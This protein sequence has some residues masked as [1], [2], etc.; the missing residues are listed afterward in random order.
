MEKAWAKGVEYWITPASAIEMDA[1]VDLFNDA[2]SQYYVDTHVTP[3][4]LM[5]LIDRE[6]ISVENSFIVSSGQY[7]VGV[8]FLAIRGERGYICGMGVRL[9][10]QGRGLGELL[11]RRAIYQARTL[12]L[13]SLQLDEVDR[14]FRAE[15]LYRK[16][17]FVQVR[18]LGM[19]NRDGLPP[20][21]AVPERGAIDVILS[22]A[23]SRD[24]L[25][26][27]MVFNEVRPCW[28][29]EVVSLGRLS[30]KFSAY[31]ASCGS[32]PC[33]Y[34]LFGDTLQGLYL[35]DFAVSPQFTSDERES[36][37]EMLIARIDEE[38]RS[39]AS[40]AFNMPLGGYQEKALR[41]TGFALTLLQQEMVLCLR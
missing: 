1:L 31:V 15:A 40:R 39:T 27:S 22:S 12:K 37:G 6:D 4:R 9:V 38:T 13:S 16:L 25:P 33:G 8:V 24:V 30:P 21:I 5:N 29:N 32:A 35:V 3:D 19:W 26:M 20:P 10:Y 23:R 18:T 14:N 17:G 41:A 2:Y 36:I 34:V 7:P 11:M 28:Q